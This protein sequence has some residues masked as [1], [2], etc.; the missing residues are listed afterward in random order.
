V[1]ADDLAVDCMP[2]PTDGSTPRSL[3]VEKAGALTATK[4]G[5]AS[6]PPSQPSSGSVAPSEI[7]TGQ[8]DHRHAV[9]FDRNGTVRERAG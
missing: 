6:W 2:G 1:D 8:L 9:T 5:G 7:R 3:A 4:A